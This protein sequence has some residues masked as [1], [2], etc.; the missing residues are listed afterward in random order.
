MTISIPLSP[1]NIVPFTWVG[2]KSDLSNMKFLLTNS[3][4]RYFLPQIATFKNMF[5]LTTDLH[6]VLQ[7]LTMKG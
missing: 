7:G 3:K 6:E 4:M 5:M 1:V 2:T